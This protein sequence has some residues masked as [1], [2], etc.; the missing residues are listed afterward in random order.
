MGKKFNPARVKIFKMICAR[1]GGSLATLSVD[2][3]FELFFLSEFYKDKKKASA[4]SPKWRPNKNP[5]ENYSEG[6]NT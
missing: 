5:P 1:D 2:E 4:E 6:I 3:M